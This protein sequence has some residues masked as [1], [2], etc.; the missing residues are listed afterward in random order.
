MRPV[1]PSLSIV[2]PTLDEAEA[3]PR[4][5]GQLAGARARGAEV[6]VVDGGSRDRTVALA[7]AMGVPV[8][9]TGT[10]RA[11]QL[12]AGVHASRGDAIWLLHADSDIDPLSDQHIVWG[13]A[14]SGRLWGRLAVRIDGNHRFLRV[15]GACMN[16]RSRLSGI[17]T[18]DQG[19]FVLRSALERIGGVPQQALMEDV[20]LSK[21]LKALCP[22]LCLPKRITTSGRRWLR[23]G[24][25]RTVLLMWSL[26]WAYWRGADPDELLQRYRRSGEAASG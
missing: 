5:L 16:L 19:I 13:L 17:A 6:L 25:L 22:P 11:R 2:I 4:L 7:E 15:V 26:R 1:P 12:Q 8:I 14:D 20:E 3:L 21:R 23:H 24:V 10:G 9:R 18:G